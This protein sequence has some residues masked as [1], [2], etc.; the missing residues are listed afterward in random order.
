MTKP[1]HHSQNETLPFGKHADGL[2]GEVML[3][4]EPNRELRDRTLMYG[5]NLEVMQPST[6][7]EQLKDILKR[8]IVQCDGRFDEKKREI[9]IDV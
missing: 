4:I 3:I 2:Y 7:R 6:L 9:L 1:L 8:Q 5:E